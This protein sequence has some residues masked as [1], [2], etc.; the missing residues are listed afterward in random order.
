M[1]LSGSALTITLGSDAS[2]NARSETGKTTPVWTPSSSAYDRAG[3]A[4]STA[5]VSGAKVKQF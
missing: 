2:G 1:S 3:N 5:T 4:S